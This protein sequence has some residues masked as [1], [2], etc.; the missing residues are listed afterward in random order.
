VNLLDVASAALAEFAGRQTAA[1]P[2]RFRH[3]AIH[4]A[5]REPLELILSDDVTAGE[6][7]ALYPAAVAAMPWTGPAADPLPEPEPA[8]EPRTRGD[9]GMRT[10]RQC[11]RFAPPGICRGRDELHFRPSRSWRPDPDRLQRCEAF[12]P[13]PGDPD[14]RSGLER[15]P[16]LAPAAP[17]GAA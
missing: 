12:R 5:D 16:I 1:T 8:A 11:A 15:W 10:C 7:L 9:P 6:V 4:Y 14:Q 13:L 3:W 17:E 2:E